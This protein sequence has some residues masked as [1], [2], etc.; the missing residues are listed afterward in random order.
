LRTGRL[1]S[2]RRQSF[3]N[4]RIQ[5]STQG[6]VNPATWTH[7]SSAQREQWFSTGY[8]ER[9]PETAATRSRDQTT[10]T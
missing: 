3:S 10:A 4:D 2:G 9:R 1:P 6:Q 8:F 5:R 7:G